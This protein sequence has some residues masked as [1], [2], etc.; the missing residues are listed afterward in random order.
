VTKLITLLAL[1]FPHIPIEFGNTGNSAIRS[2][3]PENPTLEPNMKWIGT[4]LAEISPFEFFKIERSVGRS[5]VN[6]YF[7]LH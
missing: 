6:M 2:A 5:V 7:F 4:P 1:F 3:D